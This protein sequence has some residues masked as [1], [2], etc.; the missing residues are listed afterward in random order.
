VPESGIL[1]IQKY[2]ISNRHCYYCWH[3]RAGKLGTVDSS[4]SQMGRK[5]D[6]IEPTVSKMGR[7]RDVATISRSGG[8]CSPNVAQTHGSTPHHARAR[9]RRARENSERTCAR[10]GRAMRAR[11]CTRAEGELV[12]EEPASEDQETF[13]NPILTIEGR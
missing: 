13:Q 12:R 2:P 11:A 9:A 10:A 6:A 8:S 5:R 7:K 3:I 4:V 1:M